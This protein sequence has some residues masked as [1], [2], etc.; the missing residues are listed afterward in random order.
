MG[1]REL[2]KI[3]VLGAGVFAGRYLWQNFIVK[4]NGKGFV[5]VDPSSMGMDDALEILTIVGT[6]ILITKFV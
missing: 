1:K 4:K 5:T 3:L 2:T 6:Q